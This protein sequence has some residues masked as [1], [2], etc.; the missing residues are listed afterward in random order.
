[1]TANQAARPF[2]KFLLDVTPH[3][4]AISEAQIAS[5][6]PELTAGEWRLIQHQARW[7]ADE[8]L[9]AD[10]VLDYVKPEPK[11]HQPRQRSTA[12]TSASAGLVA[13][14]MFDPLKQIP[15]AVYVEALTGEV[16]PRNGK[17]RCPL[18][19]HE[20][21]TP[22]F[23]VYSSHWKCFGCG[24][25]GSIIDFGAALYGL[26]PRGSGYFEIRRRLIDDLGLRGRV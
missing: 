23:Q 4:R 3:E 12:A 9:C 26:E 2:S 20:D 5:V 7:E 17:I 15:P 6:G 13:F 19:D 18:P 11:R 16:V 1:M 21:R 25:H 24:R 8:A 14:E 22:S 10:P